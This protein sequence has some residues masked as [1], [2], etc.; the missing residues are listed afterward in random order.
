MTS[1]RLRR[2]QRV[3]G[4]L[5]LL[6]DRPGTVIPLATF[7]QRFDAAKSTISE[8]VAVIRESLEAFG[9][10]RVET[11]FGAAGGVRYV[12]QIPPAETVGV[13]TDLCRLL[14]SPERVLPGGFL[15]M[16]DIIFSPVW[17]AALGE[18][19]ATRFRETEPDYVLTVETKGI[20]MALM[21]ARALGR[22]LVILRRDIRVTE[23]TAVHI[24]Y[25]SASTRRI[26]S[27]SLP[28]R[29]LPVGA[30]VVFIDDFMRGGGTARGM[31]DLM[32]EFDARVLGIGVL[33][34]TAEPGSKLV[35]DYTSLAVLER[36]DE[37]ARLAEVAPSAWVRQLA[38]PAGS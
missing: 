10:G 4:I 34:E 9:L 16:T 2:A 36:V 20:P 30:R 6:V 1:R 26:Q 19:F 24:N 7:A 29:A 25:V 32:D 5:K 28:R 21:T 18:I 38:A 31:L 11:H 33:L 22:P 15:Y 12:P 35:Q 13:I 17:A 8:D 23:G 3:V 37:A 27:M 14:S